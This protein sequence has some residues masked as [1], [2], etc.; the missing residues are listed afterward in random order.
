M[1]T[2]EDCCDPGWE[3]NRCSTVNDDD[4]EECQ[5]EKCIAFRKWASEQPEGE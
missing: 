4:V 5:G 2:Q 3:C 1:S